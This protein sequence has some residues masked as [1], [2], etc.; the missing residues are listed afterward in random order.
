MC[1][2]AAE[3]NTCM[4][5]WVSPLVQQLHKLKFINIL[6]NGENT[7]QNSHLFQIIVNFSEAASTPL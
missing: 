6:Y 7:H 5:T 1:C 4:E 2:V 3:E